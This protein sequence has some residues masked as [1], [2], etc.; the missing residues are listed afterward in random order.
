[1]SFTNY[2]SVLDVRAYGAKGDGTTDDTAAIQA[3][4]NAAIAQGSDLHFP[5]GTYVITGTITFEQGYGQ[6][7]FGD[8]QNTNAPIL[9]NGT[10]FV[11][12]GDNAHSAFLVEGCNSCV[13]ERFTLTTKPGTTNILLT[14]IQV[15]N[16]TSIIST[17][18][19]FRQLCVGGGN[20]LS[21]YGPYCQRAFYFTSN[22][23]SGNNDVHIFE[24]VV[25][26]Y[27]TIS[28]WE[29]NCS[30]SSGH[31]FIHCAS[32]STQDP[33]WA[34]LPFNLGTHAF[35]V[36]DVLTGGTSGAHG[37][38]VSTTIISGTFGGS[39]AVGYVVLNTISGTFQLGETLTDP[40]GGAATAYSTQVPACGLVRTL[41]GE[42]HWLGGGTGGNP[43]A[44][45]YLAGQSSVAALNVKG[46]HSEN[47]ARMLKCAPGVFSSVTFDQYTFTSNGYLASDN[48]VID[49][50]AFSFGLTIRDS[51]I[52]AI[53][54]GDVITAGV[55]NLDPT[56]QTTYGNG[57]GGSQF[58]MENTLLETTASNPFPGV[59][60]DRRGNLIGGGTSV[61]TFFDP[62]VSLGTSA[63][64][65]GLHVRGE[66]VWNTQPTSGADIGWV[67]IVGGTPGTWQPFGDIGSVV[68]VKTFGA[69]GDGTT[70]D[71]AAFQA[72]AAASNQIASINRVFYIPYGTYVINDTIVLGD[73][74]TIRG[75]G[76][77]SSSIQ[78]SGLTH[79]TLFKFISSSPPAVVSNAR[80]EHLQ[81][82]GSNG[83]YT[84]VAFEL[85]DTSVFSFEDIHIFNW[86]TG[87]GGSV[88]GSD[89]TIPTNAPFTTVPTGGHLAPGTY[90]YRIS[91]VSARGETLPSIET[92]IVVPIG[93]S[94]NKVSVKWGRIPTAVSYNV[95]GRTSGSEQLLA[96]VVGPA[97]TIFVDDGSLAPSGAMPTVGVSKSIGWW[98][99]G[100]EL[101]WIKTVEFFGDCP[102]SIGIDPN[103]GGG[104]FNHLHV[105]DSYFDVANSTSG[106][107]NACIF[108][109][110]GTD[111]GNITVDGNNGWVGAKWGFY[112][113]N[114]TNQFGSAG[115]FNFQN[116]TMEQV[117]DGTGFLIYASP[118]SD[119]PSNPPN[120]PS[121]STNSVGG[122]LAPGSYSYRISASSSAGDTDVSPEVTQVVP[123][124]TNTNSVALQWQPVPG[125]TGYKIYGRT[126]G[127]EQLLAT[128]VGSTTVVYLDD[129]SVSP[130]GAIPV[131]FLVSGNGFLDFTMHNIFVALQ[132]GVYLRG[133]SPVII[134][135]LC[136]QSNTYN[137]LDMDET[138][139]DVHIRGMSGGPGAPFSM[140]TLIETDSRY[141]QG[142]TPGVTLPTSGHWSN[143]NSIAANAFQLPTVDF[144]VQKI[145]GRSPPGVPLASA[146]STYAGGQL[147]MPWMALQG[148]SYKLARCEIHA[149]SDDGTVFASALL[150]LTGRE[151]AG[152]VTSIIW[153]AGVYGGNG[154]TQ[155]GLISNGGSPSQ[156][157]LYNATS[158]AMNWIAS[159]EVIH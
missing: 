50:P 28:G 125:A 155:F 130:S 24:D 110:D 67:C 6:K 153:S 102:I 23:P 115:L 70:D 128:L 75:D 73:N 45:F 137:A 121:A 3:A 95:F 99:K 10:T 30:Q 122:H 15:Q 54:V 21:G 49:W 44:D 47:S 154:T 60:P 14:A 150:L 38:V 29:F 25:T 116:I 86:K 68:N 11:W 17:R 134:D 46:F 93:T 135:G 36:G 157:Y 1:M 52:L 87:F 90:A 111:G 139:L 5:S 2:L 117:L 39:N 19:H 101:T 126:T 76:R 83:P 22:G 159:I 69:K 63:P 109:E 82:N 13:F 37:I 71:T 80:V 26:Q 100:R 8:G 57:A 9:G 92:S 103:P 145:K 91:A 156:L 88:D 58:V 129:G 98:I 4:V 149:V 146:S 107:G 51:E 85:I 20:I 12:A 18:N 108:V 140:G 42:I 124:G 89:L 35:T 65:A 138:C 56:G 43:G 81:I 96:N 41:A 53:G 34:M 40:G 59:S 118:N 105:E 94:T 151:P 136:V 77:D 132:G 48:K 74:C 97:T 31:L 27:Y 61:N 148:A 32:Q 112:F 147:G 7:F 64:V 16:A 33:T 133:T 106:P 84:K 66:K 127:A 113:F 72:A 141:D 131:D 62:P 114:S 143:H 119:G 142:G 55:L 78:F 120:L 144:G 104:G 152:A 158:K 79:S 123:I